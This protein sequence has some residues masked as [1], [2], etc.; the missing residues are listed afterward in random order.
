M[1][2]S[3]WNKVEDVAVLSECDRVAGIV[4]ALVTGNTVEFL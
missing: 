1:K 3:G 4:S 2:Y